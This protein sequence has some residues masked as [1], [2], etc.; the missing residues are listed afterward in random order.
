MKSGGGGRSRWAAFQLNWTAGSLLG[1]GR[2]APPKGI[3]GRQGHL[4]FLGIEHEEQVQ[5]PKS[6]LGQPGELVLQV[7]VGLLAEGV[8]AHQGQLGE[9]LE[10]WGGHTQKR[11]FGCRLQLSS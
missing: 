10:K 11:I 2:A 1:A 9:A 5:E 3:Q 4:P 7:V 6:G 8:L